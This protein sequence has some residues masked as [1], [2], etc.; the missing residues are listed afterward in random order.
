MQSWA[1]VGPSRRPLLRRARRLEAISAAAAQRWE[2]DRARP[3]RDAA[4]LRTAM[5][6]REDAPSGPLIDW[7]MFGF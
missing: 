4:I 1:L 5:A 2:N 7:S 6:E 3:L